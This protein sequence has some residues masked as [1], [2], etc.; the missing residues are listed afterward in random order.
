M[1]TK[2][3]VSAGIDEFFSK[4]NKTTAVAL[5]MNPSKNSPTTSNCVS[6]TD[7]VAY[8]KDVLDAE[9]LWCLKAVTSHY[10]YK[11]NN[12]IGKTFSMMFPDSVIARR[13]SCSE[14]KMAYLCHFGLAPHFQKLM[15]EEFT[16]LSHFTLLFDE[17]LNRTNQQKQLDLHIRYWDAKE[18]KVNTRY[19]TSVFMGH[20]TAYDV[21]SAFQT[22]VQKL[23]LTKLLQV[24]MDGP[25]VNWRFYE[26]LQNKLRKEHN[27]ECVCIGSCGLHIVNNAFRKGECCT[28]WE[29][30]SILSALYYI[31]K[32][33]P[34]RREDFL[35]S[36]ELKKLPLKFCNHRW[37][38]NAP[39]SACAYEIWEDVIRY[40]KFVESGKLP[41][42]TC[43]SF[44]TL[45]D[46]T[47][48]KL[49]PV[50]LLFFTCVAELVKPFLQVY[51]SDDPLLPFFA[52]D[53][54]KLVRHYLQ[55]F[56]VLKEKFSDKISSS[57][58]D[59]CDFDFSDNATY[60]AIEKVSA[61]FRADK[62]LKELH[63]RKEISDRDYMT[64]KHS[65]QKF[66]LKMLESIMD[67]CP[68]NYSLVR[69]VICVD[70]VYMAENSSK[71]QLKMKQVLLYLCQKHQINEEE[72]DSVLLQYLDFLENVVKSASFDFKNFDCRIMK[73]DKFFHPFFEKKKYPELW[74]VLKILLILSHGQA[75]V[76]R[77]FSI[78][79]NI[80]VENLSENSYIAQRVVCDHVKNSG[81]IHS[82]SITKEL[83]ISATSA[84]SQYRLFLEEKSARENAANAIKKRKLESDGLLSLK[85]RK[86]FLEKEILDM[87]SK[88]DQFAQEAEHARDFSL[89][90]KSN[91]LRK[92]ITE[93][94]GELKE[95]DIQICEKKKT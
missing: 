71:C 46:A 17:T 24:S 86:S 85:H 5:N 60:S 88:V 40:V 56:K 69:N 7:S 20:A 26:I 36:S 27:V 58:K 81:G 15:Y 31:F 41:K 74:N 68:I 39:V 80:E 70:P 73:L 34:A 61:G 9:I 10:S 35:A 32:D 52:T 30:S 89:L 91:E 25:A 79:K 13:F 3:S 93:K 18:E 94:T 90:T 38:E 54:H 33:S 65:C 76:E 21:F 19:L 47:K 1:K 28:G 84:H 59:L 48:D 37:L 78:N 50:K 53:I 23:N 6:L 16:K 44:V 92:T 83:R 45:T 51:Q 29:I 43:K 4:S 8:T 63:V 49:M 77:G 67:K 95:I 62:L 75:S 12:D 57:V 82:V 55:Y 11:S 87:K 66:I 14:R 22:G 64:F 42:V 2:N 72:C